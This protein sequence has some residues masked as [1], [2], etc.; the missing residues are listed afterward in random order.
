MVIDVRV[1]VCQISLN[2]NKLIRVKADQWMGVVVK[3]VK[4]FEEATAIKLQGDSYLNSSPER[5]EIGTFF[6]IILS[7]QG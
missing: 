3:G 1:S 7:L 4:V 5:I 6:L 2:E